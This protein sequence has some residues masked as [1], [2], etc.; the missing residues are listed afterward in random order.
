M[1]GRHWLASHLTARTEVLTSLSSTGNIMYLLAGN[2]GI[3]IIM[4]TVED[5]LISS[6]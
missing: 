6:L 1:Y 3:T 4:S 2:V 5:K